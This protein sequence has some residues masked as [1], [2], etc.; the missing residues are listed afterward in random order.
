MLRSQILG[1]APRRPSQSESML[2]RFGFTLRAL[3]F[4]ETDEALRR[5]E[6]DNE[7]H[8]ELLK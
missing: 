3:L 2:S 1:T 5:W 7:P 6:R 4:E 8:R